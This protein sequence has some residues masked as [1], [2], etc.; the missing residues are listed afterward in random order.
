MSKIFRLL[1]LLLI[2]CRDAAYSRDLV[3]T[4]AEFAFA[5]S[6]RQAVENSLHEQVQQLVL[7]LKN[8]ASVDDDVIQSRADVYR[9]LV[10]SIQDEQVETSQ[11][12]ALPGFLG[13]FRCLDCGIARAKRAIESDDLR[14][15]EI[16]MEHIHN[17]PS[18]I[19]TAIEKTRDYYLEK[20]RP[21]FLNKLENHY[22][23]EMKQNA[24]NEFRE[25]WSQMTS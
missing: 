1:Q 3:R 5:V 2:G 4:N 23:P 24:A 7:A 25:P 20:Q 9:S 16:E 15:C 13:V 12:S 22:G 14:Q 8:Y 10:N 21:H 11:L 19:D 17:L 18:L 6:A